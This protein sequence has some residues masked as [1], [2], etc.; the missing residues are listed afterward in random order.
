MTTPDPQDFVLDAP[1]GDEPPQNLLLT[2]LTALSQAFTVTPPARRAAA[3]AGGW[4][5]STGGCI[6]PG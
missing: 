3:D 2:A 6:A 4:T 1:T 5:P